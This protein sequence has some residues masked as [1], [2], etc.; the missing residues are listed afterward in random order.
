MAKVITYLSVICLCWISLIPGQSYAQLSYNP[1]NMG[2]GGGGTAYLQGSEALFVNPA[3]LYF[4]D[5][6]SRAHVSF[7]YNGFHFDTLLPFD[8]R[9]DQLKSYRETILVHENENQFIRLNNQE[10]TALIDRNYRNGSDK[11][12]LMSQADLQWLGVSWRGQDRAY[13]IALRTRIG[14]HYQLGKGIY[15]DT[16]GSFEE[17]GFVN[18]SFIQRYQVLHEVSFGYSESF[19]FLNGRNPGQSEFIVGIAPKLV[20]A[21]GGYEVEYVNIFSFD[22]SDLLWNREIEYSQISSGI[23][24]ENNIRNFSS[25]PSIN[26]NIQDAGYRNLFEPTGYGAGID[27]GLTY[28]IHLNSNFTSHQQH[29]QQPERSLR[30]SVSITD[31]GL[32]RVQNDPY[33]FDLSEQQIGR[34]GL[35]TGSDILFMGT[36]NEFYHFLSNLGDL[37]TFELGSESRESYNQFLPASMQTGFMFHFDWFKLMADASYSVIENAFKPDGLVSYIG[38]EIRPFNFLPLRAGTRLSKN[39]SSYYSFGAGFETP[40]FDINAAIL[41]NSGDKNDPVISSEI[42][43]AS[44]I[45]VTFH[46]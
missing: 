17:Y 43:G 34:S 11:R 40:L 1:I 29:P 36:P 35:G 44:V 2:L 20:I 31:F 12:N 26:Q 6:Q 24:S 30:L 10:K 21:G 3:N 18:Q 37:P 8:N 45:G 42:I 27:L 9:T 41:F 46:L 22:E 4:Q 5:D 23:F 14:N 39:Y 19:T 32:I 33:Q 38:T 15:A 25:S 28:L 7:L 16:G 13:A